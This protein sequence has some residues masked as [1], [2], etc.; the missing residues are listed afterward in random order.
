[1]EEFEYPEIDDSLKKKSKP[2][3]VTHIAINFEDGSVGVMLFVTR[4][5]TSDGETRWARAADRE[6]VIQE[7]AKSSY[8]QKV[9]SWRFLEKSEVEKIPPHWREYRNAW[10]LT[11]SISI[12][13]DAAKEIHKDKLR[14]LR[15]PL[16]EALDVAYMRQL[17]TGEDASAITSQ[18]QA[19]RDVTD[20][21]AIDKATTIEELKAVIP[22][23]LKG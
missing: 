8:D 1:M 7:I 17:E 23:A 14:R 16:L 13:M 9:V 21:P 6:G 11:D 2:P 12:D 5:Y 15:K 18:K 22:E 4:E 10:K 19:L 3:E 20:D